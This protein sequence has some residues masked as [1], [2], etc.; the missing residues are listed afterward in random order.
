MTLFER[1]V[2]GEI[3]S[4]KIHENNKFMAF[5]DISPLK[6]GHT[7]V[8]PKKA[9]DYLFDLP[10][11]EYIE[12]MKYARFIAAGLEK[13][14]NCKRIGTAVIGFEVPH[15]HIHLVPM[16]EI[17]DLNFSN[18]RVNLTSEEMAEVASL[19]GQNL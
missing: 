9:T 13:T 14:I 19:I 16:D 11:E 5:L 10:E 12:L 18:P 3:P 15:V 1:I 8:I 4:H 6:K 2:A 17:H 7:L